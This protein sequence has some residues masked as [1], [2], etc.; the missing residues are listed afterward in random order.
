[1]ETQPFLVSFRKLR[2]FSPLCS[3]KQLQKKKCTPLLLP[4]IFFLLPFFSYS[5]KVR[6][7]TDP[8]YHFKVTSDKAFSYSREH[9][10]GLRAFRF[11]DNALW[12]FVLDPDKN[13]YNVDA[14]INLQDQTDDYTYTR[15]EIS[16]QELI[17]KVTGADGKIIRVQK[18]I[19]APDYTFLL[20][21]KGPSSYRA[22]LDYFGAFS[23]IRPGEEKSG[24]LAY[25]RGAVFSADYSKTYGIISLNGLKEIFSGDL[26]DSK[27]NFKI[28]S[29]TYFYDHT[30]AQTACSKGYRLPSQKELTA[31]TELL[32]KD[33]TLLEEDYLNIRYKGYVDTS[34]ALRDEG[35]RAVYWTVEDSREIAG[36]AVALMITREQ[37]KV[38]WGFLSV[39]K[40]TKLTVR[41]IKE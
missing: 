23:L 17:D 2:K 26:N 28:S 30:T 14:N 39:D 31:Y 32:K 34:G 19:V 29:G 12:V 25:S 7:Y 38:R 18:I 13:P 16:G 6:Q 22:A 41:C 3:E 40:S 9:Q 37:D 8:H 27:G 10:N 5:Q 36:A 24:G 20:M 15:E 4:V 35:L 1:M 33:E 11:F 21:V